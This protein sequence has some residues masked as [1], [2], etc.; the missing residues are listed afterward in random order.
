MQGRS[1]LEPA[2]DP[3]IVTGV[4]LHR[5]MLLPITL[6]KSDL[7]GT[8]LHPLLVLRAYRLGYSYWEW[9]TPLRT[10]QRGIAAK[11]TSLRLLLLAGGC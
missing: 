6:C 5:L 1:T 7:L 4:S 9:N 3:A 2:F 10:F 11:N 8:L